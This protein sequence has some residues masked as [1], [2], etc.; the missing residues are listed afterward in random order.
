MYHVVL[1]LQTFLIILLLFFDNF[2][3]I[4][5]FL[6]L[7][8]I[9][10]YILFYHMYDDVKFCFVYKYIVFHRLDKLIQLFY[11]ISMHAASQL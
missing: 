7:I 3:L 6:L 5:L 9:Y 11:Y 1:H 2:D 4:H 10:F 8:T